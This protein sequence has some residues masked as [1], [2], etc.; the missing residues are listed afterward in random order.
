MIP[1]PLYLRGNFIH[2]AVDPDANPMG[3]FILNCD[4]SCNFNVNTAKFRNVM[5]IDGT[6]NFDLT[7][8]N[9]LLLQPLV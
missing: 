9:A 7:K 1:L 3:Y 2:P 6:E 5:Q 8:F 4:S